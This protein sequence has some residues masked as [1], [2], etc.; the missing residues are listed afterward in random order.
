MRC[1]LN[2][3][4]STSH[5]S[6]WWHRRHLRCVERLCDGRLLAFY[7]QLIK[8]YP[9]SRVPGALV[10]FMK[11]N[12]SEKW[13]TKG[14]WSSSVAAACWATV[15]QT[16]ILMTWATRSEQL[17]QLCQRN[18]GTDRDPPSVTSPYTH[19]KLLSIQCTAQLEHCTNWNT[20]NTKISRHLKLNFSLLGKLD[21]TRPIL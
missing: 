16:T 15:R 18:A 4:V 17:R 12:V 11:G 5:H 3:T 2:L 8:D 20:K 10:F 9:G 7:D 21:P 14:W 13:D 19:W 1:H 6:V